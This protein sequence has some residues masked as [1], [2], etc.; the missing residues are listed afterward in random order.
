MTSLADLQPGQK[1]RITAL[2]GDPVNIQRILEMGLIEEEEVTMVRFAP[3][4]DPLEVRV[5]GYNLSLRKSDA[6]QIQVVPL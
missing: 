4:G 2:E 1:A 6:A 3:L 5:R